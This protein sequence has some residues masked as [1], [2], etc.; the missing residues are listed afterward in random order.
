MPVVYVSRAGQ[1]TDG[2]SKDIQA[3]VEQIER[4]GGAVIAVTPNGGL[5]ETVGVWIF[6][7]K[8]VD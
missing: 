2:F 7:R 3:H 1:N 4:L 5:S 8:P 6:W